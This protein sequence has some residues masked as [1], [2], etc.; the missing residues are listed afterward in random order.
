M[1]GKPFATEGDVRRLLGD[2]ESLTTSRILAIAPSIDELAE[3][4][5]ENEEEAAVEQE[6]STPSLA[7]IANVRAVLADRPA[8]LEAVRAGGRR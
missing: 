7:R 6:P 1:F 3:A 5:R 8:K 2:L 4:I